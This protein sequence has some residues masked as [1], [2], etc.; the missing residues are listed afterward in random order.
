MTH[1]SKC[2]GIEMVRVTELGRFTEMRCPRCGDLVY[3]RQ[4][5]KAFEN[6]VGWKEGFIF[7]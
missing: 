4:Y 5:S 1:L 6:S 2:C 3:M 7:Q